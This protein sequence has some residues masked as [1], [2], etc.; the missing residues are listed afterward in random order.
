MHSLQPVCPFAH[1]GVKLGHPQVEP[2]PV[3]QAH[4]VDHVL[5][6]S[7]AGLKVLGVKRTSLD[8]TNHPSDGRMVTAQGGGLPK[9]NRH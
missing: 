3:A 1:L 4:V 6:V 2:A 7:Q 8:A 5:E 9:H